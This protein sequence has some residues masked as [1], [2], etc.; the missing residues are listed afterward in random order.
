MPPC[1]WLVGGWSCGSGDVMLVVHCWA[2]CVSCVVCLLYVMFGHVIVRS[3]AL[4]LGHVEAR[5]HLLSATFAPT[6]P[7]KLSGQLHPLHCS[8]C[9]PVPAGVEKQIVSKDSG[10]DLGI[11]HVEDPWPH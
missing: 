7:N 1:G 6:S 9:V 10:L 8:G 4:V 2:G 5:K 3:L 11:P